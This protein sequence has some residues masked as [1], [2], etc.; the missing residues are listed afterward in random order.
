MSNPQV[1]TPLSRY[2]RDL[3]RSDFEHDPAQQLAVE[4]LQ[5]LYDELLVKKSPKPNLFQRMGLVKQEKEP[6]VQ[7][8]SLIHI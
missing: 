8:L 4:H 3:T 1:D 5:R 6:P 2:K 7:G